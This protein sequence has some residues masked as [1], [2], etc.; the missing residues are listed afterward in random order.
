MGAVDPTYPLYP[1]A[2]ILAATLLLLVLTTSPMRRTWNLGV[3]FICFWLFLETLTNGVDAILWSD[4]A[5][6]KHLVYCDIVSRLQIIARVVRPMI[7]L[8]LSRRMYMIAS[9]RSAEAPNKRINLIIEW[10][11]GLVIP[12][13]VAGPLFYVVQRVRFQVWEGFGCSYGTDPS[14]LTVLLITSWLFLPPL[15]SVV[16]YYPKVAWVFYHQ[17]RDVNKFLRENGVVSRTNYFG[18]L[19]L[20]SVDILVTLPVGIV[21]T[22]LHFLQVAEDNKTIPFYS[23]WSVVHADWT[24][25]SVKWTGIHTSRSRQLYFSFWT[26]LTLPFFIFGLFGTT[27]EARAAYRRTF[28]RIRAWFKWPPPLC[29]K[30]I[31]A[32]EH[33]YDPEV[34]EMAFEDVAELDRSS[35]LSSVYMSPVP[36]DLDVEMKEGTAPASDERGEVLANTPILRSSRPSTPATLRATPGY[37]AGN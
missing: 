33:E 28:C 37:A 12:L 31:P 17:S 18:I 19:V 36:E 4:N 21:S 11:L 32:S 26:S 25:V 6:V 23:G 8:N 29:Q 10:T 14:V 2:S 35:R 3:A 27:R 15:I 16:V 7:T 9:L 20:A 34:P 5:N 24:P 22:V 13:L 1:M 30:D